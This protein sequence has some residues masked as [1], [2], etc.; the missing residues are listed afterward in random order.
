MTFL[1]VTFFGCISPHG[2][3]AGGGAQAHQHSGQNTSRE[4]GP[5]DSRTLNNTSNPTF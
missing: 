3:G 2:G 1:T 4:H 5:E